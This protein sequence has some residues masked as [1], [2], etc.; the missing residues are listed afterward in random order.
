MS[1]ITSLY[2]HKILSQ[3]SAGVE[4]ADLL[5]PLGITSGGSPDSAQMV[6]SAQFYDFF[7]SLVARDPDGLALPLRIGASMQSDE[8][9][10]FGLAWKTAPDRLIAKGHDVRI[11]SR[12]AIPAFDWN[13]EAGWDACLDGVSAVYVTYAPDLAMPGAADAIRAFVDLARRRG[14][15]RL[16]LL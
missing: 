14:V 2:V 4:T 7:A 8:Y 5:R 16:V 1:Q 15:G 6:P 13:N 11:G 9:G 12:S 3:V 10:A